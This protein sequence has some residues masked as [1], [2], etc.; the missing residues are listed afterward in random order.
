MT[1]NQ[2][3]NLMTRSLLEVFNQR[4]PQPRASA[5]DEVYSPDIVFYEQDD[6]ISGAEAL[7]ARVQQLLDDAPGFVFEPVGQ[8]AINHDMGRQRWKFGPPDGP[9]VIFG[10][11]IARIADDRIHE[12]YVFLEPPTD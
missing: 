3:T 11:D 6:I 10:T 8:P 12:L 4:D 7:Q 5:I 1:T 9:P 2:H